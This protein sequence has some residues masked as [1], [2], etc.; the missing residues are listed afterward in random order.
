MK[1]RMKDPTLAVVDTN[2]NR[3][4]ITIPAGSVVVVES[5]TANSMQMVDV[6]CEGR[7]ALMFAQDLR[8]RGEILNY[9]AA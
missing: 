7:R 3:T 6:E 4:M 9:Q 2:G 1:Y 5:E 8:T